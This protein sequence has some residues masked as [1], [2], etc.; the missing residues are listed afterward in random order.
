MTTFNDLVPRLMHAPDFSHGAGV[1]VE[2]LSSA[3]KAL[4][5]SLPR[6]YRDFLRRFGW[7]EIGNTEI[8]GLG[9]DVPKWLDLVRVT[10]SERGEMTPKMPGHLIPIHNDGAGN[11]VC[12]DTSERNTD[13]G[14][15]VFWSH[16]LGEGQSPVR[17]AHDFVEWLA[18]VL[19]DPA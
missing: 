4:G 7:A 9:S 16:D 18:D 13:G 15:I 5:V 3:E 17:V 14:S 19:K 11:H 10:R 2:S 6:S 1:S 12:I 8:Y